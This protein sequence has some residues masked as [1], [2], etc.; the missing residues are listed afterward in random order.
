M[1]GRGKSDSA[2]VAV[3]PTNKGGAIRRG[4]GGAKGGGQGECEPAK[5]A[6]GRST[7]QACH[8]RR[9]AYDTPRKRCTGWTRGGSRMRESRTYGSV[10]GARG[11]SRPYRDHTRCGLR[12]FKK[13]TGQEPRA[14]RCGTSGKRGDAPCRLLQPALWVAFRRASPAS[15][16]S[17]VCPDTLFAARRCICLAE[18]ATQAAWSVRNAG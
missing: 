10:R 16:G 5:H 4:A 2:I 11:N 18:R 8:R 6:T 13:P 7:G 14:A 17:T 12:R 15:G 1:H 9:G 3:K